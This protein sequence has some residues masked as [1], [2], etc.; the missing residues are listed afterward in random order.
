[1]RTDSTNPLIA[2]LRQF[3]KVVIFANS[4]VADPARYAADADPKR[5]HIFF[6]PVWKILGERFEQACLICQPMRGPDA[7]VQSEKDR[8]ATRML[9]SHDRFVGSVAVRGG[10]RHRK[11]L[12]DTPATVKPEGADYLIDARPVVHGWYPDGKAPSTGFLMALWLLENCP[13][14]TVTLDGFTGVPDGSNKMLNSHDWLVEQ[15]VLEVER[16]SGRLFR[17]PDP[18]VTTVD[19]LRRRYP[20]MPVEEIT[21]VVQGNLEVSLSATRNLAAK[22]AYRHNRATTLRKWG[23]RIRSALPGKRSA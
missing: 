12:E 9:M 23:A 7:M 3:D 10:K 14:M 19:T 17:R 4:A 18:K 15:S 16:R 1:M 2:E 22:A 21:E 20:D 6:G 13:W 11:P 5:L 8:E